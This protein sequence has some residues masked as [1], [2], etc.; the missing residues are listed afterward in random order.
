LDVSRELP[1]RNEEIF[2][3][4]LVVELYD[5]LDE[6]IFL[7]NDTD[8]GLS[9]GVWAADQESGLDIA[10]RIEA[11]QVQVNGGAF[12]DLAPFGGY[13]QSGNGREFGSFG[14]EEFLQTKSVQL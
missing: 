3:P 9:A 2:G 8:Y 6:G 7:A 5:D 10:R 4:V 1:I 12:N 11:G 14:F 13:K